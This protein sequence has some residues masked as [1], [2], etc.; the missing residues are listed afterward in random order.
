MF[1]MLFPPL[2]VPADLLRKRVIV[3]LYIVRCGLV[4]L[5]AS[6]VVQARR[7]VVLRLLLTM[8]MYDGL[9]MGF[10]SAIDV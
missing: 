9:S 8:F 6:D 1:A 4:R 10:Y 3:G 7:F 2:F 5:R